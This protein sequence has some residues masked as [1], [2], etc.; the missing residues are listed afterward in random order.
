MAEAIDSNN[1]HYI[2]TFVLSKAGNDARYKVVDGQQRLTTLTMLISVLMR[3]LP[4]EQAPLR[5]FLTPLFLRE[6]DGA[7]KFLLLGQFQEFFLD[8]I[9]DK[10]PNPLT[11]GQERLK[12]AYYWVKQ[13]IIQLR[14]GKGMVR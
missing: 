6:I 5:D 11:P 3:E 8:L 7:W 13:R 14:A 12:Q 4:A 2:G 10:D 9:Q 1:A